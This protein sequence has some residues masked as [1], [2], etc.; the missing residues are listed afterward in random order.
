M[1]AQNAKMS[2]MPA[3]FNWKIP[4]FAFIDVTHYLMLFGAGSD[5]PAPLTVALTQVC[6]LV[7]GVCCP[8]EL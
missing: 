5:V 1:A 8:A 7:C 4:C 3:T 6:A 2:E